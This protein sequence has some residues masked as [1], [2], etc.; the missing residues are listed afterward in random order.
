MRAPEWCRVGERR[1]ERS[2]RR[3]LYS[4]HM[5]FSSRLNYRRSNAIESI[6]FILSPH[7][8]AL[9]RQLLGSKSTAKRQI[10]GTALLD[11][12]SDLARIDIVR[13]KVSAAKQW[14]KKRRGRVVFKQYGFYRPKS[15][16]IYVN[17]RT[18]VR[19][20]TVAG[21]T[22]LNT[23]LH[24]WLHHYDYKKLGL[25]SIHTRGFYARLR[26]LKEKLICP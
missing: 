10:I 11:A 4:L 14:H 2:G 9:T 7:A 13:L 26:D 19:G 1:I 5:L 6:N 3:V 23:L 12:L 25:R 24:E 18:A 21:K 8:R 22:F 20:Q 17:N 15:H 16:Y